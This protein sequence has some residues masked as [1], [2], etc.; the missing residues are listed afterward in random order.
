LKGSSTTVSDVDDDDTD[1][2]AVARDTSQN[3]PVR[4]EALQRNRNKKA[5]PTAMRNLDAVFDSLIA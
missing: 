1:W 4:I 2:K 3:E 5:A